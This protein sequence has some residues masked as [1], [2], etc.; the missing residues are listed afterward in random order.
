MFIENLDE[1]KSKL[2]PEQVLDF[3]QPGRKKNRRGNE[4]IACACLNDSSLL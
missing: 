2:D 1:I 3:I 4:Q